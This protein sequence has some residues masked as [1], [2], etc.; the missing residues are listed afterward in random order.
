MEVQEEAKDIENQLYW[1]DR[2]LSTDI[3]VDV[4]DSTAVLSG[5]LPSYSDKLAAA[6]DALSVPDIFSVGV[7]EVDNQIEVV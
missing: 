5:T 1:D 2:I 3:V 4:I 6:E 7:V